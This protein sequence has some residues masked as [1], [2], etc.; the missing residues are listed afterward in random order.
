[1]K[2]LE[3]LYRSDQTALPDNYKE[4]QMKQV[5]RIGIVQFAVAIAAIVAVAGCANAP[6]RTC[7]SGLR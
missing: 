7:G 3:D 2:Q 4:D 1:M 6:L 5:F